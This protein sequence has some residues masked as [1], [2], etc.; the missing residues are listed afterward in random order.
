M[1]GDN[2]KSFN[3]ESESKR[4]VS[5]IETKIIV[6]YMAPLTASGMIIVDGIVVS[7]YS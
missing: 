1:V 5:E 4:T 7:C 6:G 2:L 3:N